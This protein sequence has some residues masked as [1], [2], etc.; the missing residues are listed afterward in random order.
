MSVLTRRVLVL[1]KLWMPIRVVSVKRAFKLLFAERASVVL[2]SDFSTY[3]WEAWAK[4]P[5][6]EGEEGVQTT[7]SLIKIPEV[8]VLLKYDKIHK[9]GVRLT[10]R[11]VFIRDKYI[12][13]YTGRQVRSS[14]ADID[15]IIPKSRGGKNSWD[16]LVVCSKEINRRKGDRTPDEAGLKLLKKPTKP[17]YSRLM[18]DPKMKMPKSWE[19]FLA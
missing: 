11:N 3:S 9:R 7:S 16:N 5:V 8:V 10:K 14:E 12:C 1:N 4:L 2:P 13:Q 18:I 17:T 19:K 6:A 15:H